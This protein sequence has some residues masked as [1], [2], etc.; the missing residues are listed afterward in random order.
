[1]N[2]KSLPTVE[3]I[4][5]SLKRSF[6]PVI[7]I[8]GT[9]DVFIYRWLKSKLSNS[10][11][12]L[13]AT[14]GRNNLFAIHDRRS[15]FENKKVLFVADKDAYR[16]DGIPIE[17]QDIIFTSGYC[18]ENDV[19]H[20]SEITNLLDDDDHVNFSQLKN[21]II[22][23]FA[24]ELERYNLD[25]E[26]NPNASLQVSAHINQV[27]PL[28]HS[29]ICPIFKNQVGFIEPSQTMINAVD[30]D[31]ELNVRGKQLFQILA[32]LLSKKGRFSS[33]SDKNLIEIAL[34]QGSNNTVHQIVSQ[35]EHRLTA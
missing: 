8:E 15:E 16:F 5:N 18:I 29:D 25:K 1:M 26:N 11:V 34:K 28:G 24:F 6:L 19:Y 35:L 9:D 14:G 23:W 12:S 4:I 2:S 27:S 20:G 22:R 33:F 7:I 13:Q 10:L 21:T 17:R 30:S 3:E 31:Y 32:R